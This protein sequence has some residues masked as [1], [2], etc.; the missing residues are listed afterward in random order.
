[1]F[2]NDNNS[3]GAPGQAALRRVQ[4]GGD[5]VGAVGDAAMSLPR[6]KLLLSCPFSL[7]AGRAVP[8]SHALCSHRTW[9]PRSSWPRRTSS[10]GRRSARSHTLGERSGGRGRPWA[11]ETGAAATQSLPP[12][13]P[14]LRGEKPQAKCQGLALLTLDEVWV[15]G[16]MGREHRGHLVVVRGVD[17]F[18]NAVPSQLY[19]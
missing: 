8:L 3:R 11:R 14:C 2:T 9:G 17:V 16:L 5:A 6:R 7:H 1:M 15:V 13:L 19:L 10:S 4:G 12:P 18:V